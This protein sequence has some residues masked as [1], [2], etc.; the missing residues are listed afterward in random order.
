VEGQLFTTKPVTHGCG[1][2]LGGAI[3]FEQNATIHR[4]GQSRLGFFIH[5][6]QRA[7][8][9]DTTKPALRTVW[10][11]LIATEFCVVAKCRDVPIADLAMPICRVADLLIGAD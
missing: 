6:R 1:R 3:D 5:R 11:E 8:R 10:D 4:T 9:V 2:V 7:G